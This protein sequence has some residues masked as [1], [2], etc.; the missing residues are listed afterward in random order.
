GNR[1]SANAAGVPW[2]YTANNLNQYTAMTEDQVQMFPT[3]DLDGSMTYRPIDAATGWTQVWNGENRMVETTKGTE[4]LEFKYDYMGRRVE[5]KVYDGQTLTTHLKFV[6]DGFKLVEELDGL[7]ADAPLRGYTWQP[8]EAGL[9]V[10]L[11]M[12]DIPNAA[13]S[14]HLHDANKNVMQMTD[15]VGNASGTCSYAPFGKTVAAGGSM[16]FFGFSSEVSEP[17]TG[18][19]YYNYRYYWQNVGK[20]LSRDPIG[21]LSDTHTYIFNLN[22]PLSQVDYLGLFSIGDIISIV[23]VIGTIYNAIVSPNGSNP[24]DYTINISR[25]SCCE[26]GNAAAE[27]KCVESIVL[28]VASY[29]LQYH[30]MYLAHDLAD[31]V[32]SLLAPHPIAIAIFG[33]DGIVDTL[34]SFKKMGKIGEAREKAKSQC[35]CSLFR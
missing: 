26:L 13:G 1:I 17:E 10:V 27:L 6:Y 21:E 2:T 7:N 8:N 34:I 18:L 12:S 33:V 24:R 4:R 19:S 11:Q 29:E 16:H 22:S 20:W 15:A 5:K 14:F 3:Y 25:K 9:D 23:P 31:I 30:G 28:Q 32:V 35:N